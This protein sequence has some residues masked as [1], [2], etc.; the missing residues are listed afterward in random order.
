MS[1]F[2]AESVT[3]PP[4]ASQQASHP[5]ADGFARLEAQLAALS[6]RLNPILV[7]ETRQAL[8][9]RQFGFTLVLLLILCWVVTIGGVAMVGPGIYYSAAGSVLLKAYLVV[10]IF[11]LAVVVP[12]SAYR[13][14]T[15]ER[16]ENT[17]DLLRVSTLDPHQVVRGKLGSAAVLMGVFLSAVAPCVAFTY[18]LRGVDVLSVGMLLLYITLGSLGLSM[19]GLFLAAITNQKH[20]QVLV[21]VCLVA[22]LLFCFL[23]GISI[24]WAFLDEGGQLVSDPE[25]WIG[26]GV[27]IS[28]YATTFALVYLATVALTSYR[29]ENRST[30]LRYA[31][32]AQQAVFIGWMA[33]A[34]LESFDDDM[35]ALVIVLATIYWYAMGALLTTE[36]A[37]LS[38]RVRRQLPQSTL[39]RVVLGLFSPGPGSGYL[40]VVANVTTVMLIVG[41]AMG[42]TYY[43]RLAPN[44]TVRYDQVVI[45]GLIFWSY[46]VAYVGIGKLIISTLRRFTPIPGIAGFLIHVLWLLAVS[47]IPFVMQISIR[48]MRNA[49]YT[50][51][52]WGNPFWTFDEL[53]DG[54]SSTLGDARLQAMM[55]VTLALCVFMANLP[56]AAREMMQGRVA[57]PSR[58]A[59]DDAELHPIEAKPQS[60]WDAEATSSGSPDPQPE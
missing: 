56:A 49:G 38:H 15:T 58:V 33:V 55:L 32:I 43:Y 44:R 28:L 31:M 54:G 36:V 34:W 8:K 45:F 52:Q 19:V 60:P 13:S 26:S 9:S 7:K 2:V 14:L 24:A 11:P 16:E 48:T 39:G 17:Y 22:L 29:S 5:W 12:F 42:S 6:D 25:F 21:S 10:L 51:L 46:V 57:L 20:G 1:E 41:C 23:A 53:I 40:F 37:E 59:E 35:L 18:L 30:P 50:A 4:T 27:L 47:G 3:D